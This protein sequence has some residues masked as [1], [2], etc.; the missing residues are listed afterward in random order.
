M[1]ISPPPTRHPPDLTTLPARRAARHLRGEPLGKLFPSAV[2][3]PAAYGRGLRWSTRAAALTNS[4]G[5]TGLV[6]KT[7]KPALRARS[8]SGLPA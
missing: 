1:G 2:G 5:S 4:A 7:S 6:R 3:D 8:S